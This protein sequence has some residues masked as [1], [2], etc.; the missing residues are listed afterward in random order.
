MEPK[1]QKAY[2]IEGIAQKWIEDEN[3]N[4]YVDT[5]DMLDD[6]KQILELSREL[7]KMMKENKVA[8][9]GILWKDDEGNETVEEIAVG[10]TKELGSILTSL[11]TVK[12]IVIRKERKKT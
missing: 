9:I 2:A 10:D 12:E 5:G 7:M 6:F 4:D 8:A 1:Y 3:E 11:L